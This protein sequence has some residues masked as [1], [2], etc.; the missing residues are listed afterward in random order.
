MET[1]PL[2]VVV[3]DDERICRAVQRVLINGGYRVRTFTTAQS[4]LAEQDAME[5]ACLVIDIKIPDLDGLTMLRESRAAGLETPAVF[6][7]GSA[8]LD[9][10]VKAMKLGAFDLAR[11]AAR[12]S[13][14]SLPAVNNAT[15]PRCRAASGTPATRRTL[16]RAR[17]G[18]RSRGRGLRARDVGTSQQADRGDHRHDGEDGEGASRAR[19]DE[20]G[21]AFRG[22]A[23][24]DRR[25][26]A[27]ARR[28]RR[29]SSPRTI[30]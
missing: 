10:A 11:E 17:N 14:A 5:P 25:L 16:A 27:R 9:A 6:I 28:V 21:R 18:H 29:A 24:T 13:R 1:E 20:A 12:R 26:S 3:D 2:V 8:D 30:A 15:Q 22:R 19:H 4:Y 23:G 7:T